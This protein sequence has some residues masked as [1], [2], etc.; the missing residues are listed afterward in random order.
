[1]SMY[2]TGP[3]SHKFPIARSG[4]AA[5]ASLPSRIRTATFASTSST[6]R[7]TRFVDVITGIGTGDRL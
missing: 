3:I 4:P 5:P 2:H 7:G 1:M 6:M